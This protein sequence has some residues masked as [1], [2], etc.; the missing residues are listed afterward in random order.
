MAKEVPG[1]AK[2]LSQRGTDIINSQLQISIVPAQEQLG[3]LEAL[4]E[5]P[6]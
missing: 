4:G 3:S 2:I 6:S 1:T 5:Q